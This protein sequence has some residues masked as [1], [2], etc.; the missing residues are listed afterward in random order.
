VETER[1]TFCP[2][3]WGQKQVWVHWR[4]HGDMCM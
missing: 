1:E 3:D 4:F 2:H